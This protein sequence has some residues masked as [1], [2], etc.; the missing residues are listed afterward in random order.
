FGLGRRTGIDLPGEDRGRVPDVE[1]LKREIQRNAFFAD[2]TGWLPGDDINMSVGQG[3]VLVSPL[4]LATAYSAIANGGTLWAPRLA[5]KVVEPDG[6][7]VRKIQP[8]STGKLPFTKRQMDYVRE[9]LRGVVTNGTAAG[10]FLG[11]PFSQVSVGGKTG[12]AEMPPLQ[13]ASWFAA[14]APVEHPQYVVVC[15][16]E[17]GG[18]GSETAAPVVRRILEGLYG[19]GPG[20]LQAGDAVD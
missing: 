16:V 11:F 2:R 19:F 4:Q 7:L 14:F 12:T 13:D 20:E 3:N 5:L 10:A 8:R 18:H 17:E 15:L 6:T 1:W 9:S